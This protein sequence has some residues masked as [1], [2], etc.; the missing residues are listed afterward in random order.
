MLT[1]TLFLRHHCTPALQPSNQRIVGDWFLLSGF[2]VAQKEGALDKFFLADDDDV[3]E[4]NLAI[5][6]KALP[7]IVISANSRYI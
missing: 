6:D 2:H 5:I 3:F 4:L 1:D 7:G